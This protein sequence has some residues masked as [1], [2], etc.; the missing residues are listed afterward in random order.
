MGMHPSDGRVSFPASKFDPLR[1]LDQEHGAADEPQVNFWKWQTDK[2]KFF[3]LFNRQ[4]PNHEIG[5][6]SDQCLKSG[7]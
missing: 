5:W 2:V 7:T 6:Y 4:D 1:Q 3:D